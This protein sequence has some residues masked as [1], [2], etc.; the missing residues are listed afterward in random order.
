MT[1]LDPLLK[2]ELRRR[3][4][5]GAAAPVGRVDEVLRLQERPAVQSGDVQVEAGRCGR[6]GHRVPDDLRLVTEELQ[7]P[8]EAGRED[9]QVARACPRIDRREVEQT[10]TP[11]AADGRVEHLDAPP[12]AERVDRPEP[13]LAE[14]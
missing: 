10:A 2:V 8:G 1:R 7:R 4:T 5:D 6:V 9:V 13:A 3:R 11:L 14:Q 12:M